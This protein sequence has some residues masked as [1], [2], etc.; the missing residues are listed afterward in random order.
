MSECEIVEV[1]DNGSLVVRIDGHDDQITVSKKRL[2]HLPKMEKQ[3]LLVGARLSVEYAEGAVRKVQGVAAD[4]PDF[5]PQEHARQVEQRRREKEAQ[6]ERKRVEQ[7]RAWRAEQ[8]E[9]V[10]EKERDPAAEAA[11]PYTFLPYA[12]PAPTSR[13][14]QPRHRTAPWPA[15][16]APLRSG[17]FT[18]ELEIKTPLCIYGDHTEEPPT[19][20]QKP[21]RSFERLSPNEAG[22]RPKHRVVRML[23]D[24]DG[25][26]TIPGSSLK[27]VMRSW[28]EVIT[29]S[30][31]LISESPV[32]WRIPSLGALRPA[33]IRAQTPNRKAASDILNNAWDASR[34]R[35]R[36]GYKVWLE[37][38]SQWLPSGEGGFESHQRSLVEEWRI[39]PGA[40]LV[41]GQHIGTDQG[42]GQP[43]LKVSAAA[44]DNSQASL[45]VIY[46]PPADGETVA[47][48][49]D[50]LINW[51]LAHAHALAAERGR[52][53]TRPNKQAVVASDL[54]GSPLQVNVSAPRA[55]VL[56]DGMLVWYR[57]DSEGRAG[58]FG[59]I[60]SG[61]WAARAPMAG[62][63][64]NG[65]GP[66]ASGELS[67]V[68]QVFGT[69]DD[70]RATQQHAF[71]SAS[72]KE[73]AADA[74]AGKVRVSAARWQARDDV[75][76]AGTFRTLQ[77]LSTP[78]LQSAGMYLEHASARALTWSQD[79]RLRQAAQSNEAVDGELAG[80]KAY[81]HLPPFDPKRPDER[82]KCAQ[83][84]G[85]PAKT[86]QNATVECVDRGRLRFEVTFEDLTDAE[87]GA[88]LLACSLR[89]ADEQAE[90]GWKLGIGKPVGMGSVVNT[91]TSLSIYDLKARYADPA[92]PRAGLEHHSVTDGS[93]EELERFIQTARDR[94]MPTSDERRFL[95]TLDSVARL[96]SMLDHPVRYPAMR[97]FGSTPRGFSLKWPS[98]L[99]VLGQRYLPS[100]GRR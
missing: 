37:P 80:T 48:D 44:G 31:R 84:N 75:D 98:A 40:R 35:L 71:T 4:A 57:P 5:D 88:L 90:R 55:D 2:A 32:A 8:A 1:Q 76:T 36:P 39:K 65:H 47:V 22:N 15:S 27:G 30:P 96:D 95:D 25:W 28:F 59:R 77:A 20:D 29:S 100:R 83:D 46:P 6:A 18:V 94:F 23:R 78:K 19:H 17:R 49:D 62:R 70:A 99:E 12:K 68:E 45:Q 10:R 42:S 54:H 43:R 66:A 51:C 72:T 38:T 67:P 13:D 79:Q 86:S 33:V 9:Q 53:E 63:I 52:G 85:E 64:P 97:A 24:S 21:N 50:T 91:I 41:D 61:R 56:S 74:W 87:L 11:N 81:W 34:Q 69:A 89:F 3:R 60:K 16:D 92:S 73:G 82:V 14:S 93:S 26:P 7:Q 58:W